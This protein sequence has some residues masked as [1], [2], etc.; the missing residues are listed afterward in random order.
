MAGLRTPPTGSKLDKAWPHLEAACRELKSL[1][2][3]VTRREIA[4]R[5]PA[6]ILATVP[7][8]LDVLKDVQRRMQEP[9]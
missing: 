1:G 6:E 2:K 7:G 5:V 8:L 9:I 3:A 4:K